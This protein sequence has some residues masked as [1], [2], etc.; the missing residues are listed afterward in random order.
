MITIN[1]LVKISSRYS[2]MSMEYV[3]VMFSL[4][5]FYVCCDAVGTR[6]AITDRSKMRK[7]VL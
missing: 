4:Y 7:S 5:Q 2:V 6:T 3:V 1:I